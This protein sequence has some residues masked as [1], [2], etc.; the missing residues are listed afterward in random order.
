MTAIDYGNAA[1]E[2]APTACSFRGFAF[3]FT[4]PALCHMGAVDE[5]LAILEQIVPMAKAGAMRW[6]GASSRR[7][8]LTVRDRRRLR[9]GA[10]DAPGEPRRGREEPGELLPRRSGRRLGEV[11]LAQG[12]AEEAVGGSSRRSRH[13]ERAAPRTNSDSRWE[14]WAAPNGSWVTTWRP[15]RSRRRRSPSSIALAPSRNPIVCGTS[16][17]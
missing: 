16:S 12:D 5:G 8:W 6:R 13:R 17:R 1:K 2:T 9:A 15:R 11:A 14:H 10:P 4:A 7:G 3:G